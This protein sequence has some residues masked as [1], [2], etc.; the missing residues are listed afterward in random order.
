LFNQTTPV[1]QLAISTPYVNPQF[2]EAPDGSG[3]TVVTVAPPGGPV[4]FDFIYRY[5]GSGDYYYGKVSDDGT[6]GYQVGQQIAA[7]SGSYSIFNEE[8]GAVG[9]P[10]GS[11]FIT[12]VS[13][14]GLGETST[15]PLKFA[16]GQAAGTN[17]LGSE[18]DS[19]IG[20]DGQPH[21]FGSGAPPSF[22]LDQLFG[23]IFSYAD[24]STFYT[25]TVA[26]DGS[27]GYGAVADGSGVIP[28]SDPATGKFQGYYTIYRE[29]PTDALAGQV[30]INR[31]FSGQTGQAYG[32]DQ[33]QS[34]GSN[35]LGSETGV[36]VINGQQVTFGDPPEAVL[37]ITN[38]ALAVPAI[39]AADPAIAAAQIYEQI[40]GR[41]PDSAGL[42]LYA[43]A[44]A[45]GTSAADVQSMIAHSP[46]AQH[47]IDLMF[48]QV[49]GRNVDSSGLA[50]YQNA[51]AGG[52][53]LANLRALLGQS[54]E[55]QNDLNQLYR[56]VLG[57]DGDN[58]GLGS[59]ASLIANGAS[60]QDVR[61]IL[62]HS[63][64]A[65]NDLNLIYQ[66]VLDRDGDTSGVANYQNALGSGWT[67]NGVRADILHSAEAQSDL[68]RLFTSILGRDPNAA[69]L[70]GAESR[71]GQGESLQG[72][73]NDL[74]ASGSAG[75]FTV[76]AAGAGDMAIAAPT[77]PTSF[78]FNNPG[79]GHDTILG[80]DPSQDAIA[81]SR[82]QI[83][84]FATLLADASQSG[85]GTLIGLGPSQS[86]LLDGVPLSSLHPSNFQFV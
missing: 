31:Y 29:G 18:S 13:H 84:D 6:F 4:M 37:P 50:D 57:R 21:A 43:G 62:A 1:A 10:A 67:L 63:G 78:M 5:N 59:Y 56:Q 48:Q 66:Q 75:G 61:S 72:L 28:I 74:S 85:S 8:P 12:Y 60:L 9:V 3:G 20:T 58:G 36:I 30:T 83:P 82:G 69:E 55:A 53:S 65:Q 2:N 27:F 46:E 24:G 71:L 45:N 15:T 26:D 79:F 17:G 64:E 76:L 42:A 7:G 51:L 73:E 41:A 54:P 44:L 39:D 34:G 16:G 47:D 35:G 38:P 77:G 33:S 23:F 32:V 25:G 68:R 52:A 11:V 49:L 81:L 22:P 14:A 19:V 70:A 80:F 40:L 86:I